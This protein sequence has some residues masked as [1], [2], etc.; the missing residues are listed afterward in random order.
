MS[1]MKWWRRFGSGRGRAEAAALQQQVTALQAALA[2]CKSVARRSGIRRALTATGAVLLVALGFALGVNS[3]RLQQSIADRVVALGFAGPVR[4]TDA[5]YAAYEKGDHATALRLL[6]PVAEHGDARAQSLLGLI[7]YTGRG[8]PRD[9]AEAVKWFRL[10]A[11]QGDA[12]A[13]FRL[14]LMHSEGHG[15]PQDHAE[16]AKWY[17]LAA[18]AGYARAQYNLGLLYAAGEGVSQDNVMAH[19]WFNLAVAQFPV[20]DTR[21]RNAAITSRDVVASK[22]TPEQLAQAQKLAREWNPSHRAQRGAGTS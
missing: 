14:G 7:Q 20:S 12:A 21:G 17:R 10:A 15:V 6:R 8:V 3:E 22:L 4:N 11:D 19:M 16:A 5:A 18:E 13:Q 9:D 1:I 2:K